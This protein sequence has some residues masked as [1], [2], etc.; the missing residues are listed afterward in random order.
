MNNAYTNLLAQAEKLRRHNRQ[1]SYKTKER[2]YEA[3]NRF[4][5]FVAEE[6]RL[7]KL[8]NLSGKHMHSYFAHLKE[9]GLAASTIKTEAS[10]IRFWH[11]QIPNAKHTLPSNDELILERR[12]YGTVDRTWSDSSYN[13]MLIECMGANRLDYA[14]CMAIARYAGLRI[15]EVMRLDAATA[16]NAL[17]TGILTFKGKNGLW[18]SVP[19]NEQV[20]IAL[21]DSLAHTKPGQKLF[22]PQG[23]KTH[24]VIKELEAFIRE[25]REMIRFPD[26]DG[27]AK[28]TFHGLR[29]TYVAEH[30]TR[31]RKS[32][33]TDKEACMKLAP[34]LGHSRP[35]VVHVYLTKA[36]VA[37]FGEGGDSDV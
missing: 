12:Q 13:Q 9:K 29:H 14:A 17:K 34:L 36:L 3:F 23:E 28:L 22:V 2:Y 35:D 7:E 24:E 15:H 11:D 26:S 18:R 32:G 19:I 27:T 33:N 31:L 1:G 6:Y 21:R 25:H 10:A 16:R 5:R 20:Q 30:Y 4:L 37:Q 8:Q